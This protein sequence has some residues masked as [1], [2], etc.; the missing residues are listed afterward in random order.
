MATLQ[1][2]TLLRHIRK[3]ALGNCAPPGSDSQLLDAFLTHRDESA[4]AALMARHGPLVLRVCRRV[5]GQEQDAEDAF[6][7]TFLVLA[8]HVGSI[9]KRQALGSWLYGV[10]YRTAMEA[11]RRAARRRKHEGRLQSLVRGRGPEAPA[12]R[13][14]SW[15][16]V[17]TVLD[18]E[19]QKLPERYRAAFVLCVLEGKSG[20]EAAA[21]LGVKAGTVSSRLTRARQQLQQR[22]ARREIKLAAVL[23]ALAVGD[24]VAQAVPAGLAEATLRAGLAVAAGEAGG[25]LISTEVAALAAGMTRAL[26][27]TKVKIVLALFCAA[28]VLTAVGAWTHQALAARDNPPLAAQAEPPAKTETQKQA[29]GDA[30]E[31]ISATGRVLDPNGRPVA[32][33]KLVAVQKVKGGPGSMAIANVGHTTTDAEGRFTLQLP[34]KD[35]KADQQVAVVATAEG[36]GLAWVELQGPAAPGEVTLRLVKDVPVRG[37]LV[38]TEGKPVVGV[39]ATVLGIVEVPNL[40]A[41]LRAYQRELRHL[42]EGTGTRTLSLPQTPVVHVTPS[43]KDGWFTIRGIGAERL[44]VLQLTKATLAQSSLVVLTR[45]GFDARTVVQPTRQSDVGNQVPPLFGPSFEQVV[46]PTRV[47]EGTVR[48]AGTGKPVAGA[49]IS[50]GGAA[51]VT[52]AQGHYRLAGM[53]KNVAWY[54]LDVMA[55]ANGPLINR[56]VKVT[57]TPGLEPMKADVA[58]PR[59]VVVTGRVRDK[60]TGKGVDSQVRFSPLPGNPFAQSLAELNLHAFVEADGRFRLVTVPGP[61]IL[62]AQV[63]GTAF[64]IDGVPIYPYKRAEIDPADRPR[65]KVVNEPGPYRS[66]LTAGGLE[67]F[68]NVN[69]CKVLDL[70]ENGPPVTC[71]LVFDPGIT[72]PVHVQDPEG[73]PLPGALAAGVSALTLRAVPLKTATCQ[74]YALDPK[75]PRQM[76]FLHTERKL[77]AVVTVRGDEKEPMTVRLAATGVLTGRALDG[78]GQPIAG[79]EVHVVYAGSAGQQLERI[80]GRWGRQP[81]TDKA[82]HFRVEGI[83]PGLEVQTLGFL[84]GRQ[85]LVPAGKL[86]VRPVESAKALDLGDVRT[87]PR[88]P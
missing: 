21:E 41:F 36:F 8:R 86:Q 37:R 84:K 45:A 73:K 1:S 67:I 24:A 29:G 65:V 87:R 69:A 20:P 28:A 22:L 70:K 51:A 18:E 60:A 88:R 57:S 85:V 58:L 30:A 27:L 49:R 17:Q 72:R 9:R 47:I 59:G 74:V 68:D 15:D 46:E 3:L 78:D 52:D 55:P 31:T 33:A 82:G 83:V 76:V 23:A 10:A 50:A 48:D 71:D 64:K 54:L 63:V 11:K 35:F 61:G 56:W 6:Q 40:E 66:I 4:F 42:D 7:A 26:F 44:A 38:T 5:L 13:S 77:A 14:P 25:A 62:T 32:K 34:R 53:R 79:A 19:I 80:V 75:E 2:G 39:A 12:Q 16:D 81:Q 43:D